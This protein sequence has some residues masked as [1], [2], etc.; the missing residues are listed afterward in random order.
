MVFVTIS[1]P[2]L[3]VPDE[4]LQPAHVSLE[5]AEEAAQANAEAVSQAS[6]RQTGQKQM[7]QPSSHRQK[8]RLAHKRS[9]E[10]SLPASSTQRQKQHLLIKQ[11]QQ[12]RQQS[13]Q[14]S[15]QLP[16]QLQQQASS[17]L[18]EQPANNAQPKQKKESTHKRKLERAFGEVR[19]GE[20]MPDQTGIT[21]EEDERGKRQ[22]ML[23]QQQ[24]ST[25]QSHNCTTGSA[26]CKAADIYR[27]SS[28][29]SICALEPCCVLGCAVLCAALRCSTLCCAHNICAHTHKSACC[30]RCQHHWQVMAP[31]SKQHIA[32]NA[33]LPC[34]TIQI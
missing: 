31:H 30:I 11:T 7:A 20:Q 18:S 33:P 22:R 9:P 21:A 25:T 28:T 29:L 4:S 15:Q 26:Q 23:V 2:L 16:Q 8:N 1:V 19:N 3:Q 13:Q 14:V 5:A 17:Q 32:S 10:D 24:A 27:L 6:P 34:M 12:L